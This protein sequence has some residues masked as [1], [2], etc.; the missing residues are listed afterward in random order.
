MIQVNFCICKELLVCNAVHK[1]T[2][3]KDK[4]VVSYQM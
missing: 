1:N 2:V 4:T 3:K